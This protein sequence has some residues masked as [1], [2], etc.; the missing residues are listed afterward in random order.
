MDKLI[1]VI[2]PVYN[3]ENKISKC[4]ESILVQTYSNIQIVLVNDGSKDSSLQ[5][6]KKYAK[7]DA[8]IKLVDQVNGGEGAARNRGIAEAQGELIC[9]VDA[10]D[11][12]NPDFV[13]NLYDLLKKN[14]SEMSICGFTE[15]KGDLVLN[16]TTGSTQIMSQKEAMENLLKDNSF[17]GYVWNKM[18]KIDI[19]R[20]NNIQFDTTLGVWEDVLFVFVYM[21]YV[22]KVV[23]SPIPM[24]FY[25]YMENSASHQH[26][27]VLGYGAIRAKNQ[28]RDLIPQ[29]YDNVKRQLA[30]RYVQSAFAVIRNI[31]YKDGDK[32]SEYYKD[33]LKI[34]KKYGDKYIL[35][36]LSR[37]D[38]FCIYI[39]KY[40]PSVLMWMYKIKK[41]SGK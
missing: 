6:C 18:F 36:Y 28:I 17:K 9:F 11:Y 10:D 2:V 32:N 12:V 1:S 24:Y 38:R 16:E 21:K 31:G 4:L 15:L 25:I 34:I 33:S 5:I 19:I 29:D 40:C 39:C 7:Q 3:A 30:I 41:Y 22:N 35:K 20:G 23:F 26:N 27:Y 13:K 37:K 14:D 8:R